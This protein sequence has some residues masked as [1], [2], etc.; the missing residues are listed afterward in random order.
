MYRFTSQYKITTKISVACLL[1]SSLSGCDNLAKYT[2]RNIDPSDFWKVIRQA[3]PS[4]LRKLDSSEIENLTTGD[5]VLISIVTSGAAT[6]GTEVVRLTVND[7]YN[8]LKEELEGEIASSTNVLANLP[9]GF[10]FLSNEPCPR[11]FISVEDGYIKLGS[12]NL[13]LTATGDNSRDLGHYHDAGDLHAAIVFGGDPGNM[14]IS[15]RRVSES[16][17]ENRSLSLN[18]NL[19]V[20][21]RSLSQSTAVEG[22]T[23]TQA[24]VVNVEPR[25]IILRLCMKQ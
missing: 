2:A 8:A 1:L 25:H 16:F 11:G 19:T 5:V 6:A 20:Q 23:D 9:Q 22:A 3:D 4:D 12:Q 10:A 18:G 14:S 24:L 7:L 21:E 15:N 13:S 17:Q